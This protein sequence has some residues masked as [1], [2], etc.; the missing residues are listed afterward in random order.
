[1]EQTVQKLNGCAQLAKCAHKNNQRK[2]EKEEKVRD[3]EREEDY[4]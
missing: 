1:M 3:R 4:K 2:E